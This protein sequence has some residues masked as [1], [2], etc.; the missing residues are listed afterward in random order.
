MPPS[1]ALKNAMVAAIEIADCIRVV[2]DTIG[3]A[4]K[5]VREGVA[6][7]PSAGICVGRLRG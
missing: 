7:G 1:A 5:K 4:I 2:E 6:M 3:Q